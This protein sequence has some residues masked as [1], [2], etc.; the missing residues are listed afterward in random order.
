MNT[1]K[2]AA[3]F[4]WIGGAPLAL[5]G[6]AAALPQPDVGRI[7]CNVA[8]DFVA[9]SPSDIGVFQA[10]LQGFE[11]GAQGAAAARR[12]DPD[13]AGLLVKTIAYCR[14]RPDADFAAAAAAAISEK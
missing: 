8:L 13:A 7:S 14:T 12:E 1:L 4:A 2:R 9:T 10:F 11:S 6:P 3:L 5:A